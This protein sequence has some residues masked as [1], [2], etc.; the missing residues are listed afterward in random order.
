MRDVFKCFQMRA[1][2]YSINNTEVKQNCTL[3][4]S[5]AH[6]NCYDSFEPLIIEDF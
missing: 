1:Y 3:T 5:I 2:Y 4:I 6:L